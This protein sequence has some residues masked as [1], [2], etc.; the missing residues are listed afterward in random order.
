MTILDHKIT[1]ESQKQEQSMCLKVQNINHLY[2]NYVGYSIFKNSDS[3][4][5]LTYWIKNIRA[6]SRICILTAF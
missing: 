6:Q 3:L 4:A 1:S 2:L 5:P